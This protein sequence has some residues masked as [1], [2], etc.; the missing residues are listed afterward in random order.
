MKLE[1]NKEPFKI[2]IKYANFNVS[3]DIFPFYWNK[4]KSL[5]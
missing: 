4:F 2:H 5:L 1:K 3:G